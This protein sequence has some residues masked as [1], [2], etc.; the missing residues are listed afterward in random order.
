MINN[1]KKQIYENKLIS[2]KLMNN[3]KLCELPQ[4]ERLSF[5]KHRENVYE[6]NKIDKRNLL[7]CVFPMSDVY[8]DEAGKKR[9]R[10][11]IYDYRFKKK[12]EYLRK[13][14]ADGNDSL[15]E[16]I[17]IYRLNELGINLNHTEVPE[18]SKPESI[19]DS[20][21]QL[22]EMENNVLSKK[23]S[24][25][26]NSKSIKKPPK[27]KRTNTYISKIKK[28]HAASVLV[29]SV[30]NFTKMKISSDLLSIFCF[31]CDNY[32]IQEN[33]LKV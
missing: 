23:S 5:Y 20:K 4:K 12:N 24:M 33:P 26:L 25:L 19:N 21:D 2:Q 6:K 32:I 22:F 29:N 28:G 13:W 16:N 3:K 8:S 9:R 11:V 7:I 30:E 10:D 17:R 18:I 14:E 31:A 27:K 1:K 15:P